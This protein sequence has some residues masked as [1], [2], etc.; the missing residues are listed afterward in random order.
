M[1][2]PEHNSAQTF[3]TESVIKYKTINTI[4]YEL[5]SNRACVQRCFRLCYLQNIV[6]LRLLCWFLLFER[7]DKAL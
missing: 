7:S 4:S 5:L 3:V 1:K 2:A 6:L